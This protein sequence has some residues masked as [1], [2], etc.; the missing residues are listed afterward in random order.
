ML[1]LLLLSLLRNIFPYLPFDCTKVRKMAVEVRGSEPGE[2]ENNDGFF[3]S[4]QKTQMVQKQW[5][6]EGEGDN[7]VVNEIRG[8]GV[9]RR[10][11]IL[12]CSG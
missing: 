7:L 11:K 2:Q 1:L 6:S 5:T 8:S 10:G 4:V 12:V 9:K 3:R